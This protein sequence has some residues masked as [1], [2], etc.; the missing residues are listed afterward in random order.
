MHWHP[1][2]VA[3]ESVL[4]PHELKRAQANLKPKWPISISMWTMFPQPIFVVLAIL[5]PPAMP[6]VLE[7]IPGIELPAPLPLF[8]TP[9]MSLIFAIAYPLYGSRD[10]IVLYLSVIM[11]GS[12][13]R[14]LRALVDA[15]KPCE[16]PDLSF[17]Y[18]K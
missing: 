8:T 2:P 4:G 3:M 7:L 14:L 16:Q 10:S 13:F 12:M 11:T 1:T 6:F 18:L 5:V 9:I 15:F 17:L